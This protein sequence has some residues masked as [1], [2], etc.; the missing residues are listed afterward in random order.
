IRTA[1]DKGPRGRDDRYGF[2][3]VNPVSALNTP[4]TSVKANPL[5]TTPPS[6]RASAKWSSSPTRRAAT[7]QDDS[8][9]WWWLGLGVLTVVPLSTTVAVILVR[10]RRN[11][12][13]T[14]VTQ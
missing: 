12:E 11:N 2:G 9:P 13:P 4:V 3:V 7:Q 5:D 6:P 10:R 14:P 1:D 8:G